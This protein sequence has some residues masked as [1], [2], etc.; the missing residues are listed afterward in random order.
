MYRYA[1]REYSN[2]AVRLFKIKFA[3]IVEIYEH[4]FDHNR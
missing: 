4:I 2:R 1:Y 3:G